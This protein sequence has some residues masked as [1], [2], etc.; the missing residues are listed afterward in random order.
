MLHR[1]EAAGNRLSDV[2]VTPSFHHLHLNSVDPDA[3]IDFYTAQF[4]STA[5]TT[6][7]GLPALASPNNVLI[8]F[9]RVATPPATS[10]Q[11]AIWHFGW[12]AT[13]ARA[14]LDRYRRR[15]GVNLLPLYTG[16]EN[17]TVFI[18][19]DTWPG[20]GGVLGRTAA[21]IA[22]ARATGVEPTR[23]GGFAYMEG[24][25]NAIVEYAGDYPA[26]RFNH[27]HMYQE[28]PLCAELWYRRHLDAS[29][30][31]SRTPPAAVTDTTCAVPRAPDLTFPAL[32]P[33][34]MFRT[35]SGGVAFGDV[36]LPWY[37]RQGDQPLVSTRGQLY[38]HFALGVTSLD[39]W[40][41]KLRSEGV[42]ILDGPFALGD[43][44]AATIAGPSLE[45]IELVEVQE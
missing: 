26:E 8:L 41:D 39:A 20:T 18:S 22:E 15:A 9:T 3:A 21:Q 13:D 12:H 32:E 35:P 17:G 42:T 43:T 11:T 27:V 28:D 30:L 23:V 24:P 31:P 25:D 1:V 16:V 10:P 34:G 37:M 6:W 19:S 2:L 36:W 29:P 5:R 45:A 40:L 38:D 33:E 14:S 7:G 4:P 44:R